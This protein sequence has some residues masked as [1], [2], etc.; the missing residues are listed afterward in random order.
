V[1]PEQ[2]EELSLGEILGTQPLIHKR[3][4]FF[5]FFLSTIRKE[6]DPERSVEGAARV[7]ACFFR[8]TAVLLQR[9]LRTDL[10]QP[11]FR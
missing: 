3:L 11:V 10:L 2:S 6:R 7:H 1:Y 4:F 5:F 9:I 8:G